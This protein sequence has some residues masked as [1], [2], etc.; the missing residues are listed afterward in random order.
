[1]PINNDNHHDNRDSTFGADVPLITDETSINSVPVQQH[2]HL[3]DRLNMPMQVIANRMAQWTHLASWVHAHIHSHT[4]TGVRGVRRRPLVHI[5]AHARA[6]VRIG[7]F[8][9][10]CGYWEMEPKGLE[11]EWSFAKTG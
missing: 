4:H 9:W 8:I 3:W 2:G 11:G 6:Y 5:R 10:I 1:M 7:R